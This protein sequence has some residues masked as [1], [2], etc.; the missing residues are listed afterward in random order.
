MPRKIV[1]IL[2][3]LLFTLAAC[4]PQL[5][6]APQKTILTFTYWGSDMEKAA[7]ESMAAAFEQ[8]NPDIDVRTLQF[9][10]EEYLA[11]ISAMILDGKGPDLGYMPGLQAPLWAEQGKV[12]DLTELVQSD[13]LLSSAL[14]ETRYYYAP[15]KIAGL[16]TA[17]EATLLFYNKTLFDQAG[18]PYPPADPAQAWTWDQFLAAAQK[19]TMDA[20]GKHADQA[21]FDPAQIRTYGAAFDK[22]YEGWT[23]YPFVFSNGGQVVNDDGSRLLLDSPEASQAIQNLA[24]LMWVQH[25]APTPQQDQNLP[26]YVAMLQTGN[27]AMHISGQW[28]L[29][30]YASVKD[31]NFGVA[32]LPS[33]E[34]PVTVILGSPT[35]IFSNTSNQEA[36]IRFYKFH[37]NPEAVD[38]F[39]RGLWM[40]LQKV[41]YTEPDKMK[42][43][44][45]NPTH[46]LEM[47]PAF[48]DYVVNYS[49][50]LPSYYLKNYAE[51]LDKAVRPALDKI[52]NNEA[53]AAEALRQAVEDAAPLMQGR[54]DR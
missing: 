7:I 25:V 2:S 8:A 39:A 27:L 22:I 14:P 54:W 28:S 42:L 15:G 19:L 36:A 13:P 49:T 4:S 20:N 44:L 30:D 40:P 31:L 29:L 51:V 34:T 5:T 53:S 9:P 18:I 35:V 32:V 17:V 37:N 21:G 45:D 46:P 16:N 43:W 52:W 24:D 6:P 38:L 11:R 26:G 33:L 47:R 50:P 10:Y 1:L 23:F 12:M 48:T 41:Y 3:M